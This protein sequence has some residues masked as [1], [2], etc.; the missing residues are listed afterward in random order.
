M[1]D[2]AI[3]GLLSEHEFH[4]YEIRKRLRDELGLFA[5]ISFGSLYPALSRLELSGAVIGTESSPAAPAPEPASAPIPLT[6]S[7]GG[8]RAALRSR[9]AGAARSSTRGTKRSRKVYRITDTGRR[10]FEELL[11]AEEPVGTDEA[12]S[13]G[14]R[15]A[16]ARHL[17]PQA[18]LGLLERRRDQLIRRLAADQARAAAGGDFDSYTRS[19]V[20]HSTETTQH[21]ISWLESLIESEKLKQAAPRTDSRSTRTVG[22]GSA[23]AKGIEL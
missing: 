18:R 6:G 4:G 8:E 9:R 21:D 22:T 1:L 19:L 20:E 11:A 15:L 3:L 13:F 5:N 10:V 12:R 16:F 2:L 7:L 14:L 23:A 17:A